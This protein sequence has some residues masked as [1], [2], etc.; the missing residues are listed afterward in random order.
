MI[1]DPPR[2]WARPLAAI[3][4]AIEDAG[5]EWMEANDIAGDTL[6]WGDVPMEVFAQAAID[7]L[8]RHGF[9]NP[10]FFDALKAEQAGEN[11]GGE[12]G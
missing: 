4:D 10:Q 12:S 1:P 5:M 6:G 2:Q 7:T 3:A 8:I 9:V 11:E